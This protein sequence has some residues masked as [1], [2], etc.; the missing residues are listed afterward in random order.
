MEEDEYTTPDG[1]PWPCADPECQKKRDEHDDSEDEMYGHCVVQKCHNIVI[2]DKRNETGVRCHLCG[3]SYC[4]DHRDS[5]G[6]KTC[7]ACGLWLCEEHCCASDDEDGAV[8]IKKVETKKRARVGQKKKTHHH[9][10]KYLCTYCAERLG[11]K[12]KDKSR[13]RSLSPAV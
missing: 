10:R 1:H 12:K 9:H 4:S 6:G 11:E 8:T 7:A 13:D 3:E 2:A 5:S